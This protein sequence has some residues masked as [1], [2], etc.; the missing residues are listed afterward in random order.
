MERT[1][2]IASPG[3]ILTDGEIYGTKIFP[4]EGRDPEEFQE[5]SLAYYEKRMEEQN[6]G[7]YEEVA[8]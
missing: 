4:E 8:T 7:A 6:Y 2:L 5:V 3:M 1:V